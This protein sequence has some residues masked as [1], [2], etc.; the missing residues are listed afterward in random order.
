M[1]TRSSPVAGEAV[2]RFIEEKLPGAN[3]TLIKPHCRIPPQSVPLLT[4]SRRGRKPHVEQVMVKLSDG[5]EV[6]ISTVV[7]QAGEYLTQTGSVALAPTSPSQADSPTL[8]SS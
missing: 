5:V 4:T 7:D 1:E 8:A 2:D 6:D 3:A